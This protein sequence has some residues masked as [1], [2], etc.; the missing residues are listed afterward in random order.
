LSHWNKHGKQKFPENFVW[1][2]ASAQTINRRPF[3]FR[4]VIPGQNFHGR[5]RRMCCIGDRVF[6]GN[7]IVLLFLTLLV[8]LETKTGR[9]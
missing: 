4:R 3:L 5:S 1:G 9:R 6:Y 2:A 7:V 8:A